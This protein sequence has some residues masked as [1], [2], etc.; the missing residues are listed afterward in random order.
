MAGLEQIGR[1]GLITDLPG[2][3]CPP[4]AV[5]GGSNFYTDV[6]ALAA[7]NGY[8]NLLDAGHPIYHLASLVDLSGTASFDVICCDTKV[9]VW[10]GVALNDITFGSGLTSSQTWETTVINGYLVLTNNKDAPFYWDIDKTH[11]MTGIVT[12]KQIGRAHV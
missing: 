9:Y 8:S 12:G 5:P 10:D 6:E 11:A 4:A 7:A 2:Y 1:V 3:A